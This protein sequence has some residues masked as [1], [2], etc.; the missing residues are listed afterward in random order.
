MKIFTP[1]YVFVLI[2][3]TGTIL[4][5]GSRDAFA[6]SLDWIG[7]AGG[8]GTWDT[9]S[10]NWWTGSMAKAWNNANND[11]A[12]FLSNGGYVSVDTSIVVHNMTFN[13]NNFYLGGNSITLSGTIPTIS[14]N[15]DI[16]AGISSTIS[17][18][19][20]IIKDGQGTL[21]LANS[22]NDYS[23]TTK[24]VGGILALG[25]N[26]A[27]PGGI[28][29]SGGTSNLNIAGGIVEFDYSS[30]SN[31]FSRSLGTGPSQVQFT[32]SGG[33]YA[34]YYSWKINLGGN[35]SSA[36]VGQRQFCA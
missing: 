32:A 6:S 24:V 23:G 31:I 28:Y 33:F 15:T 13:A 22:Y 16:T 26:Y 3:I 8:G 14:T 29:S 9:T 20:G 36:D 2:L 21:I 5:G 12:L 30:G 19:E 11:D 17:G 4:F 27:L 18:S 10:L 34:Q 25:S 1:N 35:A 7:D